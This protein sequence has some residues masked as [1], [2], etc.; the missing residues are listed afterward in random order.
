[1]SLRRLSADEQARYRELAVFAEHV[2]IPAQAVAR[3]WAQTGGW[4]R[5]QAR[6]FAQRLFD[7]GLL[8]SYQ[9]EPDRLGLHDVLRSYLRTTSRERWA[10]WDAA[11]VDAYRH[12]LPTGGGWAVLPPGESYLWS[13]LATHLCGAGRRAEL[14]TVLAD[15]R[16]LITKLEHVGPAGLEAD[17]RLSQRPLARALAVVVRQNAHVLGP[18]DPTRVV[19][20]DLRIPAARSQRPRPVTRADSRSP[21]RS[22]STR[23]GASAGSAA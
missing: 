4:S 17:L 3:L 13:W 1:M 18:L 15:P 22:A 12:L 6:R 20:G 21:H 16:W 2:T 10:E 8:A 19:G 5:F 23:R 14:E 9:R 11:M 7:L